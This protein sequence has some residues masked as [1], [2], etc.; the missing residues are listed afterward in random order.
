MEYFA[1]LLLNGLTIGAI[2]ALAAVAFSLVYGVVRMVNFA[3]GEFFMLGAF[4]TVSLMLDQISLFGVSVAMPHF[5]LPLAAAFGIVLAGILGVVVDRLAYRPLRNAPRLA[6]LITS[7]AIS[8]LLQSGAQSIWGAEELRFPENPLSEMEVIV[9]FNSLYLTVPEALTIIVAV[10]AM[11][12]VH[13][14]V[15]R[16]RL[17]RAMRATADNS[18]A[19]TLIGIP[20]NRIIAIAFLL[21]S[22]F[23]ALAGILYAQTYGFAHATMGFIPALKA[24]TAAVLGGIGSIPGAALGGLLLG[25]METLGGGYLPNGNAWKDAISFSVLILLLYFRPQG[26]LGRPETVAGERGSLL[27][28]SPQSGWLMARVEHLL[29]K[30]A[31]PSPWLMI[32]LVAVAASL[33][34]VVTSDY[35]LRILI[36]VLIYGMLASGLNVVVGFAGLLDLGYVAFWAVGSYFT[37]II[38]ILVMRQ[39]FGIESAEVW[40]LMYA[41]F[42]V[43]GV[44]AALAAMCIGYP[45]LKLRGDYL[46]IM[47]LGFGEIIRIVAINWVDLTRGPMGIRDIPL[48]NLFGYELASAQA[49]YLYALALAALVV[50]VIARIVRSHVGRAWVAIREDEDAAEAMGIPTS[51]YKLYAYAFGGFIGGLVGTFYAHS[52]QYISPFNFSL[53]ENILLLMLV[54]LGGLGTLIGPFIGALIWV[55]F[56][57]LALDLPFVEAFPEA[58]FALLGLLL[59]LLMLYRPQGLAAKAR[60]KLVAQ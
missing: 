12:G 59:I 27:G 35:W 57:Q 30:F 46:A 51:R 34:F 18:T 29:G 38:F 47:T 33:A 52:Q 19:S 2:Y 8:V 26:L 1:Q 4:I 49:Q 7:I 43:G 37:S 24:L 36:F 41:N 40:W 45:T 44:L 3:F 22:G 54:V 21:G 56:L 5:A 42:I 55:V 32:A 17:G 48:P 10:V 15:A 25:M 60:V 9:L 53:F 13:Q 20:V 16:S 6:P 23:A 28:N 39:G 11:L 50:F 31:S 58:R 14:F